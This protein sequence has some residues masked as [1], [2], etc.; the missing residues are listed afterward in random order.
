M[1]G[2]PVPPRSDIATGSSKRHRAEFL[3]PAAIGRNSQ[4]TVKESNMNR[5]SIQGN[6]KLFKRSVTLRWGKLTGDR[7]DR[8]VLKRERLS[9]TNQESYGISRSRDEAGKRLAAW[10]G[11]QK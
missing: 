2:F 10:H 11:R 5:G 9:V 1:I 4:S 3:L 7:L 8:I 6:W